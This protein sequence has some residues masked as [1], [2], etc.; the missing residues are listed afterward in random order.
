MKVCSRC[1]NN[2]PDECYHKSKSTSFG[3][4]SRCKE[5]RKET[6]NVDKDILRKK[7]WLEN[8]QE[9]RR[10]VARNYYHNHKEE[11]KIRNS[12]SERVK[13]RKDRINKRI[14]EDVDFRLLKC[15]RSR[16]QRA[17]KNNRKRSRTVE[18]IGCSVP[19]CRK[20]LESLFKE[21]MS[22][23]NYGKEWHIDHIKPCVLF[24]MTKESEQKECFNFKNLQPLW[25]EDNLTKSDKWEGSDEV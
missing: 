4:Q 22:W 11:V 17:I 21:G 13:K 6:I 1:K 18:L 10:E 7:K 23:E 20:Y 12:T 5:C 14:K 25:A 15:L 19:A 24:D 8:N 16:I 3:L 2:L 9:R